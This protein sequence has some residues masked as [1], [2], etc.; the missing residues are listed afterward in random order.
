MNRRP[1]P[2]VLLAI[3][4]FVS[5]LIY[6]WVASLYYGM[7]VPDTAKEIFVLSSWPRTIEIF[8]LPPILGLLIYSARRPAYYVVI[9]GAVYLV[10]RSIFTFFDSNETDPIFPLVVTNVLSLFLLAYFARKPTR[11][12][13]FDPTVRWWETDPRY[14]VNLA[15][16]V[17]RIGN[18]PMEAWLQNLALGGAGIETSESGFLPSETIHVEFQHAGTEIRLD[19]RVI[20]ERPGEGTNQFV[21]VQWTENCAPPEFAKLR[22]LLAELKSRNTP[23]TREIPTWW[24]ELKGRFSK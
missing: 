17:T 14:V 15:G 9:L 18:R 11:T 4:Q 22:R 2:I 12:I 1:W 7:S 23:T 10:V 3:L 21:G 8:F 16:S 13:Y 20:W 24:Q 19:A 6:V 5:P